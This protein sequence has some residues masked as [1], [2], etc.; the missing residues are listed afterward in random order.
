MSTMRQ[1]HAAYHAIVWLPSRNSKA[2]LQSKSTSEDQKKSHCVGLVMEASVRLLANH[3]LPKAHE[4]WNMPAAQHTNLLQ[5]WVI[6][7]VAF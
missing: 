4:A 3:S 2:Q 6:N 7:L 1:S 5:L